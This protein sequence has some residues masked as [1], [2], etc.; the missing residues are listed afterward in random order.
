MVQGHLPAAIRPQP[1]P[2]RT[3]ME[4]F[5]QNRDQL[6]LLRA[7]RGV[8]KGSTWFFQKY[9][10]TQSGVGEAPNAQISRDQ[11]IA[12]RKPLSV[13]YSTGVCSLHLHRLVTGTK[14]QIAVIHLPERTN[15]RN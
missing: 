14:R 12:F 11:G 8:S 6:L 3:I 1:Q 7:L 13:G 9:Q 15:Y 4:V 10:R 5:A 2:D